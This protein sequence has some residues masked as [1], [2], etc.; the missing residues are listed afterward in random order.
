MPRSSSRPITSLE[1]NP[2]AKIV[3]VS[4]VLSEIPELYEAGAS[5]VSVAR[6][7]EAADLCAFLQAADS[8]LLDDTRARLNERL[9]NR[10]EVLP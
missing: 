2:Q 1:M 8:D 9:A 10:E 3:T 5:Y 6:L 7:D 4:E